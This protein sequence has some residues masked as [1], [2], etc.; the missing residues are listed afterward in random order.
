MK[1]KI[2]GVQSLDEIHQL[3]SKKVDLAGL[4]FIPSSKRCISLRLAKQIVEATDQSIRLVALF[5]NAGIDEVM[6]ILKQ[7]G[8]IEYVQ[9]HGDESS[10]YIKELS[11]LGYKV[12]KSV[13]ISSDTDLAEAEGYIAKHQADLYLLDRVQQG[14]GD[15]VN[16]K[17]ANQLAAKYKVFLAGGLNV[18]NLEPA[19]ENIDQNLYGIDIASGVRDE[20]KLNLDKLDE[21]LQ[22]MEGVS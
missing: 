9:L 21:I 12:I 2:C 18:D 6:S 16:Q 17:V 11:G 8:G 5:Q 15:L 13:P 22:I 7:L 10:A 20:L 3:A 1:L 14:M 19:L 4:N